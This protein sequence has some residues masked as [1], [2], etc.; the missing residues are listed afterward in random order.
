ML[1]YRVP[2]LGSTPITTA[3]SYYYLRST[4][5]MKKFLTLSFVALA[6]AAFVFITSFYGW[7]MRPVVSP[8]D[9]AAFFVHAESQL[10]SESRG[11]SAWC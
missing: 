6:W 8:G 5:Y 11:N 3:V 9:T 7:W 2:A 4:R 10:E 1:G